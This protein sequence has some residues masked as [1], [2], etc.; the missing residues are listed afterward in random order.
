MKLLLIRHAEP[1]YACD[2]LTE[3]GKIEA[4]LLAERL[5]ALPPAEGY[6]CSPLGRAKATAAPTM[7]RLG[8]PLT[9]LPWLAEFRGNITDPET[10]RLRIPWDLKPAWWQNDPAYYLKDDWYRTPLMNSGTVSVEAIYRETTTGL[11]EL[12]ARHGYARQGGLYRCAHN[13]EGQLVVFAHMALLLTLVGHLTGLS[14][15]LLW[16]GCCLPPSSVTTLVTEERTP[17]LVS[18]RCF[19]MGDTSHLYAAG[20]QPSRMAMFQEVFTGTDSTDTP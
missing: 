2:G 1:D 20:R 14:P 4:A 5:S 10:G 7:E 3:R 17:G 15:F 19:Q 6:Y 16:H 18:F 9:V 12:L 11:D 8:R 13:R